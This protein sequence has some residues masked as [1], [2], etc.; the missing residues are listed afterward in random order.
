MSDPLATL[1]EKKTAIRAVLADLA[2]AAEA[3]GLPWVARDVRDTATPNT[4][5][6]SSSE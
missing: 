3:A 6:R 1:D 4:R 5:S 2:G